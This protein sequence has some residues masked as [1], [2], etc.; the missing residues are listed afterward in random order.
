MALLPIE[1]YSTS[2]TRELDRLA[3]A[4]GTPGFDLM[5]RAGEAVLRLVLEKYPGTQRMLVV[6]GAGNNAGDGYVVASLASKHRIQA[7]VLPLQAPEKLQGSAAE[8]VALWQQGECKQVARSALEQDYDLII[9]AVLGTGLSREVEADYAEVIAAINN[10]SAKVIAVDVPS[11]INGDTGAVMGCAVHAVMTMTFI[12]LNQ[13]LFT[14]QA[15]DFTGEVYFN[16][17]G[18]SNKVYAQLEPVG[19]R[20]EQQAVNALL[21]PRTR[22]SHKGDCGHVLIIGGNRGMSGAALIAGQAALRAG[23]GLVTIATRQGHAGFLNLNQ[24]ELMCHGVSDLKQLMPLIKWATVIAIGPGL[25]QDVWAREV[26]KQAVQADKPLVLDADALNLLSQ[27]FVERSNW[28]LTP[29]PGEAARLSGTDASAVQKTR[30]ATA[31]ELAEHY[32]ATVLLKGAGSIVVD[33][34]GGAYQ[35]VDKGNPGMASGGMGDCLTGIVAALIGQ[36]LPITEA[37]AAA[38]YLHGMAGDRV[39]RI[40]GERGMVA[41]DLLEP[42]RK[43]INP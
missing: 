36:G 12:G 23:A 20:V 38:A 7:D 29:H 21:T 10:H 14:G 40:H 26:F 28:V 31:R 34:Q 1:L 30:Y 25:G 16:D 33:D 27:E 37:T 13:G 11:G 4:A 8:A 18:V 3:I 32:R 42:L 19:C 6:C 35:L 22:T 5:Q 24:P 2:Q 39:A 41:T 15:P 17:L 43:L 9:D